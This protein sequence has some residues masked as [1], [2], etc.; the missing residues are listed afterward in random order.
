MFKKILK[1]IAEVYGL[2][3]RVN[4]YTPD[5]LAFTE[6]W[7]NSRIINNPI[8]LNNTSY[9]G[10]KGE[11][12]L[13]GGYW[14][15]QGHSRPCLDVSND[16]IDLNLW[17]VSGLLG[18]CLKAVGTFTQ[19]VPLPEQHIRSKIR[20]ARRETGTFPAAV[21]GGSPREGLV[22]EHRGLHRT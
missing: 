14:V 16:K 1:F 9:K 17:L 11:I 4:S 8:I 20:V 10:E 15:T 12:E 18:P 7:L 21:H 19:A 5:I 13:E 2:L 22:L 3:V 6:T